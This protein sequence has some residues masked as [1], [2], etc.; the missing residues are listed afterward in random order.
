MQTLW[1]GAAP[2]LALHG[3]LILFSYT[4]QDHLPRNGGVP[5]NT[6]GLAL[7]YQWSIKKMPPETC[8]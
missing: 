1:R 5:L 7:L 3:L 4:V 2:W 6:V 8:P